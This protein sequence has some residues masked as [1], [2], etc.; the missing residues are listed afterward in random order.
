MEGKRGG[1]MKG[2]GKGKH[3]ELKGERGGLRERKRGGLKRE[4][5]S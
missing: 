2:K 4:G 3:G 5:E 1:L